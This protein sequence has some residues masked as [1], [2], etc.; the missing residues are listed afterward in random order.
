MPIRYCYAASFDFMYK[1]L[2]GFIAAAFLS[3]F[4]LAALL[5]VEGAAEEGAAAASN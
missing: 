3:A 4:S 5:T 2:V 1:P